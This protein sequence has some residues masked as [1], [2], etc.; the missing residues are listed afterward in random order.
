MF[1]YSPLGKAFEKQKRKEMIEGQSKN[2]IKA[3]DEHG[4]QLAES[5]ELVKKDFNIHGDSIPLDDQGKVFNELIEERS[6]K[7]KHLRKRI[8]PHNLIYNYKNEEMSQRF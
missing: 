5:N 7:F 8:N 1:A 2:Q 3:L 6:S 4:K